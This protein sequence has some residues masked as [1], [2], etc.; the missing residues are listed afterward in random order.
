MDPI[1][2]L[3]LVTNEASGSN[4][5]ASLDEIRAGCAAVGIGIVQTTTFPHDELPTI[6]ELDAA[7]VSVVAVYT[8]DGT[9]NALVTSL[10][11]WDGAVLVLPGGTM[12]LLYKRLHGG[13]DMAEVLA[14]AAAGQAH[15]A[16][17]GIIQTGYGDGL[18]GIMAGP[19]TQWN[20]VREA[21]RKTD[22]PALAAGTAQA[23]GSSVAS[24]MIACTEPPLGRPE[25]Y[26]LVMLT[27][28]EGG[29]VVDAYYADTVEDYLSQGL[30]LLKR[31][32]REG[33]HDTLGK[34]DT[35]VIENVADEPVGL[36]VDGEPAETGR[37]IR[38]VLAPCE[39][40]LLATEG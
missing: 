7:G 28:E 4:S 30:A 36:L 22:I 10:Y 1:K 11:G 31:D 20:D 2:S 23:I 34:V 12:N 40:D 24:P 27:P 26:P 35:L 33:P 38:F 17:P 25:G 39:V 32:F 14:A 8:G 9:V 37:K 18:S 5:D 19:A 21:L 15:R 13:R 3:W 6:G 29:F 16:R